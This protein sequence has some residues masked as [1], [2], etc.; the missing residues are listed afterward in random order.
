[1]VWVLLV[2]VSRRTIVA[3]AVVRSPLASPVL[4]TVAAVA[5]TILTI[6]FPAVLRLRAPVLFGIAPIVGTIRLVRTVLARP[7][8][9]RVVGQIGFGLVGLWRRLLVDLQFLPGRH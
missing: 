3:A 5:L 1:M 8:L 4:R 6:L 7:P 2:L 9:F